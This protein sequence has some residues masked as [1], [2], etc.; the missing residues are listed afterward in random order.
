MQ[1]SGMKPFLIVHIFHFLFKLARLICSENLFM[2]L[3]SAVYG[4]HPLYSTPY[5]FNQEGISV[6][7]WLT[8]FLCVVLAYLLSNIAGGF[9]YFGGKK[10]NE[11]RLISSKIENMMLI[12]FTVCWYC[13]ISW[14]KCKTTQHNYAGGDFSATWVLC[15]VIYEMNDSFRRKNCLFLHFEWRTNSVMWSKT[16]T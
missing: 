12:T 2:A 5:S 7:S 8:G 11:T 14:S 3:F 13:H 4:R 16:H 6:P 15:N 9:C 10:K 1:I